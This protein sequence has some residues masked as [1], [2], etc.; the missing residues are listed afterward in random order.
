VVF[1]DA[2]DEHL[3]K[4][5]GIS[6]TK[7]IVLGVR[8]LGASIPFLTQGPV[9]SRSPCFVA[10]SS[11]AERTLLS[12][13]GFRAHMA[14]AEPK[15]ARTRDRPAA[16]TRHRAGEDRRLGPRPV[17]TPRPAGQGASARARGGLSFSA[18]ASG[19]LAQA[20]SPPRQ[21]SG[22]SARCR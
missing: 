1:G 14:H 2:R 22:S 13:Q 3:M 11:L 6:D 9:A 19:S 18:R 15:G 5:V 10:V 20:A 16:A 17:R 7:A 12:A 8:G 4:S 21:P